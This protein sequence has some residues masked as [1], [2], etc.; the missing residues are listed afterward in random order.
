MLNMKSCNSSDGS[1]RPATSPALPPLLAP[2]VA[3]QQGFLEGASELLQSL[4][5]QVQNIVCYH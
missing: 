2:G 3:M 4:Q 5:A 1:L